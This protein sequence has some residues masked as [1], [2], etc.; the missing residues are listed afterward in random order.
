VGG[1]RDTGA[2]SFG[3]EV[4]EEDE[5]LGDDAVVRVESAPR[6]TARSRSHSHA[7]RLFVGVSPDRTTRDVVA[8]VAERLRA[9]GVRGRFVPTENYHV[10]VAFLGS[11]SEERVEAAIG[12]VRDAAVHVAPFRLT[13]D[14]FGA[15][16]N[17]RRPRAVWIGSARREPAVVALCASVRQALAPL[18]FSLEPRDD[19]HV[20]IVRCDRGTPVPPEQSFEAGIV[21]VRSITVFSSVTART[22]ARYTPLAVLPLGGSLVA[23]VP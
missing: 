12:A 18:G 11:V 10:T 2:D 16:P 6:P 19:A 17:L 7:I 9:Q 15:F 8:L 20:T 1:K 21:D 13:L 23:F 3:V 22:G 14:A 4:A 5:R